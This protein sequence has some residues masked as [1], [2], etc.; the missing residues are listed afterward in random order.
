MQTNDK[1]HDDGYLHNCGCGR[2]PSSKA[3]Q[4]SRNRRFYTGGVPQHYRRQTPV[5]ERNGGAYRNIWGYME[6]LH[7]ACR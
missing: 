6:K 1:P 3:F 5:R 2:Y 7:S 4:A